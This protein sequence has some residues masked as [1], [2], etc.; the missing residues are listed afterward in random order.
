MEIA[1]NKAMKLGIV[2]QKEFAE[3]HADGVT[4]SALDYAIRNDLL[5]Y[6]KVG[7]IRF[8]VLTKKSLEYTPNKSP[9]RIAKMTT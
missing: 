2:S 9:K 7:R 8:I 3:E 1:L 5:D 4:L 6:V